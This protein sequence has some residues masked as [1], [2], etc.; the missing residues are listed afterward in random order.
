MQ[1]P[2]EYSV[3]AGRVLDTCSVCRKVAKLRVGNMAVAWFC[4]C[5]GNLIPSRRHW[6]FILHHLPDKSSTMDNEMETIKLCLE[7]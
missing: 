5:L 1:E 2:R 4:G 3:G 6:Q 7:I